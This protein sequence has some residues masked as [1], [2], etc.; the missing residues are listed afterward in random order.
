MPLSRLGHL[1]LLLLL[2]T[3]IW[4]VAVE[5]SPWGLCA[6]LDL[7]AAP[8]FGGPGEVTG[9]TT[10]SADRADVEAAGSSLFSGRV[11]IEQDGIRIDAEQAHYERRSGRVKVEQ[12]VRLNGPDMLI[13]G[14]RA[15]MN[16]GL[17]TGSLEQGRYHIRSMHASGEAARITVH[18]RHRTTLEQASYSTCP[19]GDE[20]WLLT[21]RRV[22]LDREHNTGEAYHTTL[23]FMG[24]PFFYT[25]YLNF[26][27][28]GRKSGLLPASFG[29]S[30]RGGFELRTPFYW[31]I[32]PHRDA[33]FT[34]RY[35]ENRGTLLESEL[36]YLDPRW[37]GQL[38]VDYLGSDQLLTREEQLAVDPNLTEEQLLSD[39]ARYFGHLEHRTALPFGWRAD[40]LYNEVSDS[41][42]F[43][44]L[45]GNQ[46]QSSQSHL[47]RHL[48]LTYR[49][50]Y[51]SLLARGQ[52][53]QTLS[54]SAPYSR[55]PQLQLSSH[56]DRR[57]GALYFD[58]NAEAVA[59][60]HDTNPLTGNRVDLYPG[61]SL[62]L[63][64]SAW[65]LTPRI[66][67][68]YTRYQLEGGSEPRLSRSLGIASLD[69]GLFFE[70][71]LQLAN[72]DYLQT[73]EPRLYY[74]YV[75]YRD[76]DA[77]PIFDSAYR[78]LTFGQLFRENRFSGADRVGDANQLT[79]AV[80]S[81]L[82][83]DD[84][85]AERLT[86]SLGQILYLADREVT[87]SATEPVADP[88][89]S[90]YLGQLE[91]RPS[92]SLGLS[93]DI[94]WNP[95]TEET[96]VATTRLS[97]RPD[98]QRSLNLS[99][100]QRDDQALEQTDTALYW[101]LARQWQLLGRWQ[102]DLPG[103]RTLDLVGGLEYRSCCWGLQLVARNTLNTTTQEL[104][105]SFYLT[106]EL[107][108]LASI[109]NALDAELE[110]GVL[111]IT[112]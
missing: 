66:A 30:S 93:A 77:L 91:M 35:I 78:D 49:D 4:A 24:V 79:L 71:R 103:D 45:G 110:Q 85:G 105:S 67:G 3:P 16:P 29:S 48:D 20:D 57:P 34:P 102:Y 51:W 95:H 25:P 75:P 27:L 90:A 65:F 83:E 108:G 18:D 36:R 10:L 6:P 63:Q 43:D 60:D 68:R 94:R 88:G 98:P 54:G 107:K 42:Y 97:Y 92:R 99:Y 15:E 23:R 80:T 52:G 53:Y 17:A 82:L 69:S 38:N 47:E 111:G 109:G 8:P 31:N 37:D 87:L 21:A 59:F 11:V 61:V 26:P 101:P 72:H 100:R 41:V 73:L 96:E 50:R 7:P 70:R 112:R 81:R 39:K 62:P 1:S 2:A 86:V 104:E 84:S 74:L 22:E 13:E 32:A 33:T 5:A 9:V 106:L 58:L 55:L 46:F 76:Q 89:S 28:A 64:G 56:N 44:D 12:G 19:P 14:G 40:L